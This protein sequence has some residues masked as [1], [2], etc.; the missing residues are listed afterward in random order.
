MKIH[1]H[2]LQY[3]R[4]LTDS[5]LELRLPLAGGI[6]IS[7]SGPMLELPFGSNECVA[8]ARFTFTSCSVAGS[9]LVQAAQQPDGVAAVDLI[10][11]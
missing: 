11:V 6:I 2:E 10:P 8:T 5:S 7:S 9:L 4:V 3:A 1:C